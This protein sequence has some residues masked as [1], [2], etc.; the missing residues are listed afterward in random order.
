[1]SK[2]KSRR[3]REARPLALSPVLAQY[4][5]AHRRP[6]G[7]APGHPARQVLVR[8]NWFGIAVSRYR[9]GYEITFEDGRIFAAKTPW[10]LLLKMFKGFKK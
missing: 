7:A 1:M 5:P 2:P 9:D 10:G 4:L 3:R 6:T 8:K